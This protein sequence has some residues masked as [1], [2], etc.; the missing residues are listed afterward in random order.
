MKKA[1]SL[2]LVVVMCLSLVACG[3]SEEVKNVESL[4]SA[5]GTVDENSEPAIIKAENAYKALTQDDKNDVGNYNTLLDAR[6]AYDAIPKTIKLT[7]SNFK[8]FFEVTCSYG[9]LEV[10]NHPSGITFAWVEMFL[11]IYPVCS[12]T[13]NNVEV[14]L[15]VTPPTGWSLSSIDSAYASANKDTD[16]FT[17][18]I[19]IPASGEYTEE[20]RLGALMTASKPYSNCTVQIVSVTGTFT[21]KK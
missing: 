10:D 7:T 17:V 9:E 11:D 3:K 18:K 14:T 1:F 6:K 16:E 15:K 12:G 4:I 19:R 13:L 2:L 21:E 8:D 5:I 20:H